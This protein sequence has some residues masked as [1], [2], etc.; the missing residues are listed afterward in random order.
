MNVRLMIAHSQVTEHVV[1]FVSRVT[2]LLDEALQSRVLI[3]IS[4]L[5]R[6]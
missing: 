2:A 3:T 4:G 6:C 5:T 1:L